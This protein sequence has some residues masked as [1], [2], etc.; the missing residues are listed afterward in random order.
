MKTYY[1]SLLE[2]L[3]LSITITI[4]ITISYNYHYNYVTTY[5]YIIDVGSIPS[6]ENDANR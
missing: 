2:L 6:I 4:V 5:C 1:I 3:E